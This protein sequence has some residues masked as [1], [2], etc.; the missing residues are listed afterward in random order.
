[1][2]SA[3]PCMGPAAFAALA[4]YLVGRFVQ[5]ALEQSAQYKR[6]HSLVMITIIFQVGEATY[7]LCIVDAV[8]TNLDRLELDLLCFGLSC[9]N[10][11]PLKP[12]ILIGLGQ[13][14][15]STGW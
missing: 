3:W 12:W 6:T 5:F 8:A 2:G 7:Y 9:M 10:S 13:W 15:K 11:T 4:P 1:M 14:E